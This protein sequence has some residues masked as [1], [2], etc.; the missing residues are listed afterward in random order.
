MFVGKNT[1]ENVYRIHPFVAIANAREVVLLTI[2]ASN[3]A[4]VTPP[5]LQ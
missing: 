2:T 5:R 1:T 4:F 3:N